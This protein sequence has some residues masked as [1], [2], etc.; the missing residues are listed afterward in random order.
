LAARAYAK[1]STSKPNIGASTGI[2]TFFFVETGMV[3][4]FFMLDEG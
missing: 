3:T 1:R 4:L 2:V